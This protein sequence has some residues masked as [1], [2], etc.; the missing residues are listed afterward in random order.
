MQPVLRKA[1][2]GEE[3]ARDRRAAFVAL[4][5]EWIIRAGSE[6]RHN[7]AGKT[8]MMARDCPDF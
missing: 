2:R 3:L 4:R 7:A 5:I 1:R 8:S 6:R